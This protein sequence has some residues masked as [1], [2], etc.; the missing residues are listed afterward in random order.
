MT[1]NLVVTTLPFLSV[2]YK[3]AFRP[4]TEVVFVSEQKLKWVWLIHPNLHELFFLKKHSSIHLQISSPVDAGIVY[5]EKVIRVVKR[6]GLIEVVEVALARWLMDTQQRGASSLVEWLK[7]MG[8]YGAP[9]PQTPWS[10]ALILRS[11]IWDFVLINKRCLLLTLGSGEGKRNNTP[12][13][14]TLGFFCWR[15]I[16]VWKIPTLENRGEEYSF[17]CYVNVFC[18]LQTDIKLP[19]SFQDHSFKV[20]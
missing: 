16:L 13:K 1:I 3:N 9:V 8:T 2:N 11:F 14:K 19:A 6:S 10:I 15:Q 12:M 4:K 20:W 17:D 5:F 7:L 18:E